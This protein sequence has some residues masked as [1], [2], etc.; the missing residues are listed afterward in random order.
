MLQ[1]LDGRIVSVGFASGDRFVVGDWSASPIGPFRDVMWATPAGA[2]ILLV[3]NE[4]TGDFVSSV[5][6]FEQIDVVALTATA[7]PTSLT[8]SAG[9]VHLDIRAGRRIRMP[10]VRPRWFTRLVEDPVARLLLDVR[11]CGT[12]PTGVREWYR[13]TGLRIVR[14]ATATIDGEE[15]GPRGPAR[16]A[17][18]VGFGEAPRFA[19]IVE[20]RTSID[21]AATDRWLVPA[22][23]R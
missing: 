8:L 16:P 1:H 6:R 3:G 14:E 21:G 18:R 5:Y 4:R 13:A 12:S 15:L 11:T 17:L 19:S 9:R 2:R 22:A 7:T 23:G 20:L 10:F